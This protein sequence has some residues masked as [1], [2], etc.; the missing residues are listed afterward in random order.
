MT[1]PFDPGYAAEPYLTLCAEYP[2][3]DVY[4]QDQF[5]LE[6][7]PIFHRG[8]LDGSMRVLVIGQDPAQHESVVRGRGRTCQKTQHH[9]HSPKRSHRVTKIC[10]AGIHWKA[11]LG[12]RSQAER[13]HEPQRDLCPKPEPGQQPA[14]L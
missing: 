4:P 6:W 9:H 5:R 14:A 2:G 1:H 8:R 7:G 12:E 10:V 11:A 13:H 3:P